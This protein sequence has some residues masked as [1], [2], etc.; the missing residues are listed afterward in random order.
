[1][2][3]VAALTL[4]TAAAPWVGRPALVWLVDAGSLATVVAYL[5][6]AVSF[7]V[8][9]RRH[10]GL[11]RPYRT[12]APAVVGW[13]AVLTTGF[14]ILLYLPGSPSALAWPEEWVIV[15]LWMGLGLGVARGMRRRVGAMTQGRQARLI[16]GD[17][18]KAV[19]L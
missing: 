9:R 2:A 17:Y 16:L 15:L 7:L 1:M 14:F 10:P 11:P 8:I 13:L 5:L 18:A 4:V 3:V 6:V 19:R 12:P